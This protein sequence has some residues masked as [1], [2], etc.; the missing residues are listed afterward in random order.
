MKDFIYQ[1]IIKTAEKL[2]NRFGIS[3][4][5]MSD[6]AKNADVS[7]ATIFNNFGNKDGLLKAVLDRKIDEF[8]KDIKKSAENA[9]S[10]SERIKAVL[11]GRIRLI[12]GMKFITD[13]QIAGENIK[14]SLFL[15]ELDREFMDKTRAILKNSETAGEDLSS[16][17]NTISFMLK[18][19]E[20]GITEKF[21][22]LSLSQVEHDIDYFLR[23]AIP[24]ADEDLH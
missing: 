11:V 9:K 12:S 3:K 19:I 7:R 21:D 8:R 22:A 10:V 4:T 20:S 24:E 5:A 15:E 14:I 16:L 13:R 18:G 6:V 17:L 23:L 1:K 2:F